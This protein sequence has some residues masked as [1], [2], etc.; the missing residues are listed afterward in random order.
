MSLKSL[1]LKLSVPLFLAAAT[2][3]T[4]AF[5][6]GPYDRDHRDV[7]VNVYVRKAPPPV[8]YERFYGGPRYQERVDY[9]VYGPYRSRPHDYVRWERGHWEHQPRGWVFIGTSWR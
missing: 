4:G 8:R 6:A 9:R 7:S 2:A 5:A 3:T 1:A